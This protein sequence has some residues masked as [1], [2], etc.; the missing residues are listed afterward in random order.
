MARTNLTSGSSTATASTYKTGV[1]SPA[2]DQLVLA[3]VTSTVI[4]GAAA[5]IPAANGNGLTWVQ[6]ASVDLAGLPDSRLTCLRAMGAA[7]VAGV[8]TFDFGGA[9]Q[10]LCAWSVF[11]YDN[12]DESGS[13]GSGAL[14]QFVTNSGTGTTLP[15]LLGPLADPAKSTVAGAIV[16]EASVAVSPGAGLSQIDQQPFA[17]GA[18]RGTLQTEDRIGGGQTVDWSWTGSARSAAIAVEIKAQVIIVSSPDDDPETLARRFEPI[19]FFHP[20]ER[21]FPSDAQTY[22]EQ[23][24]L[25]IAETPF[26]VKDSWDGKGSPFPRSPVID[27]GKIAAVAGEAGTPLNLH[28][29]LPGGQENFFDLAGWKDATGAAQAS[30]TAASQNTYADRDDIADLYGGGNVA[31]SN[32]QF[33]YH[34]EFFTN[35]RLQHLLDTVQL[36]NVLTSFKNAALVCYYFFFPAHEEPVTNGKNISV[37]PPDIIAC[38]NVEAREFNNFA[39][40]WA[41]LAVLLE[42]SDPTADFAPSILG[43]SGRSTQNASAAQEPDVDNL[44]KGLVMT[45]IRFNDPQVQSIG[46]HPQLFVSKGTHA[47][48]LASGTNTLVFP[49]NSHPYDCGLSEGTPMPT[50][51]LP[52]DV[53]PLDGAAIWYGKALAGGA[54]FG[55]LGALAGWI[56]GLEEYIAGGYG[57]LSIT[58]SANPIATAVD[59]TG[60]PGAGKVVRPTGLSV[61]LAGADLQDWLSQQGLVA[62]DGRR[63]DFLVDRTSQLWWP[64][65]FQGGY[66]GRWGPRVEKDPFDRRAGMKFPVFWRMFFRAFAQGKVAGVF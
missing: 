61:P 63:H 28:D 34:A 1:F 30:V 29:V 40:E 49:D 5:P 14:A 24:S 11:E 65:D 13:D 36:G 37:T 56:W 64:G 47:F 10:T 27:F 45:V 60:D 44:A 50:P 18:N 66:Q 8:L 21:F 33:W 23:S 52:G 7:P 31:L 46:E 48:Y 53:N 15:V 32:S 57:G 51:D 26:D 54:M 43:F 59:D 19:L 17:K 22:V 58:G 62:M 42:R 25:W 20:D 3:F 12:I 4:G 16:V 55:P 39:G 41:C 2:S 35:D 38:T 9:A 6:V